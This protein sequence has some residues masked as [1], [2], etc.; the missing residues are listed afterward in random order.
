MLFSHFNRIITS[1]SLSSRWY[2]HLKNT[3]FAV[4]S[5]FFLFHHRLFVCTPITF[6]RGFGEEFWAL[7]LTAT[8]S[9]AFD[10]AAMWKC[11]LVECMMILGWFQHSNVFCLS[12]VKGPS[13]IINEC[14]PLLV[15]NISFRIHQS[16]VLSLCFSLRS[17]HGSHSSGFLQGIRWCFYWLKLLR[18]LATS[19]TR[20]YLE[21]QNQCWERFCVCSCFLSGLS[22][23]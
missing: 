20:L 21:P 4:I 10:L 16:S 2:K 5:A 22:W 15:F 7:L 12:W 18:W 3:S 6:Y 8:F 11:W 23:L 19:N 9:Q 14:V 13:L 17:E 1:L